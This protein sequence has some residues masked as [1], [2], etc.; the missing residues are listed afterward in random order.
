MG[1]AK[2]RG[3]YQERKTAAVQKA[4]AARATRME[5]LKERRLKEDREYDEKYYDSG[6]RRQSAISSALMLTAMDAMMADG[7]Q[8]GKRKGWR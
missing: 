7:W 3:T 1:E 8:Y 4:E 6:K 2:R 5:Q